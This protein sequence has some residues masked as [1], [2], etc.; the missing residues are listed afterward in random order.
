MGREMV[1]IFDDADTDPHSVS[2]HDTYLATGRHRHWT[3]IPRRTLCATSTRPYSTV[4]GPPSLSR[5]VYEPSAIPVCPTPI[6][7]PTPHSIFLLLIALLIH[8]SSFPTRRSLAPPTKTKTKTKTDLIIVLRD[9][10]VHEQGKH[11]ELMRNRRLYWDL[12]ESQQT[13]GTGLGAGEGER[14]ASADVGAGAEA[15]AAPK[16]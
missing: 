3:R 6:S 16:M 13:S 11:D 5:I 4:V 14:D 7:L 10:K 9:G 12:W 1:D 2:M 15:G 8:S